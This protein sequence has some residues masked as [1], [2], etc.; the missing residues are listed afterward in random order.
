MQAVIKKDSKLDRLPN[1]WI[2]LFFLLTMC[3]QAL[4]QDTQVPPELQ[5]V[6]FKK[7]FSYDPILRREH[8]LQILVVFN[9]HATNTDEVVEAFEALGISANP[10]KD[11]QFPSTLKEG[12]VVYVMPGVPSLKGLC[13]ESGLLSITGTVEMVE[14]GKASI[15]VEMRNYR[16]KIVVHLEQLKA[17]RHNLSSQVLKLA[18]LIQ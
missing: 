9:G 8:P 18:R 11:S 17:E 1:R 2:A 4:G 12:S 6:I 3:G 5:A 13:S 16:P 15:G 10:V 14:A 7:V